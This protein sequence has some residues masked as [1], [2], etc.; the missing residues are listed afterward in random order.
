MNPTVARN[1]E[2]AETHCQPE[3]PIQRL[4]VLAAN[5]PPPMLVA[6]ARTAFQESYA[7]RF[8]NRPRSLELAEVGLHA[9]RL[10]RESDYLRPESQADLEGEA[11]IYLANAK[12]INSAIRDSET[13]FDKAGGLLRGTGS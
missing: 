6:I 5:S 4:Q 10:L 3:T 13:A 7:R 9:A 11:W 2:R 12:R 8:D 1:Q